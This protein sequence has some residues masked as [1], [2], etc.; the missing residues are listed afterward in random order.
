MHRLF[1]HR[2]H[3]RRGDRRSRRL[4]AGSRHHR[5]RRPDAGSHLHRHRDAER[6]D[7][8]RHRR[9]DGHDR[10]R[11]HRDAERRVEVRQAA[12]PAGAVGEECSPAWDAAP[13]PANL[14]TDCCPGAARPADAVPCP[15][16]SNRDCSP[17][18]ARP[19][20]ALV[21]ARVPDQVA[22]S[23]RASRRPSP[24]SPPQQ[25]VP[26][27]RRVLASRLLRA[28]VPWVSA[29]RALPATSSASLTPSSRRLPAWRRPPQGPHAACARPE[30][31]CSTRVPS[32]IRPIP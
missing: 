30:A 16:R 13:C 14:S 20:T 7:D 9:R 18:A 19:A 32:R 3:D 15:E 22:E 10:R 31:R 27:Q 2:G 21:P 24:S 12:E 25:P 5:D 11:P 29:S 6:R 23:A 26:T 1:R 8:R 17:G 4:G 28:S